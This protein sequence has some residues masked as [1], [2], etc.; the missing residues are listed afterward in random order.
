MS[1]QQPGPP[2]NSSDSASWLAWGITFLLL[3][4]MVVNFV[5]RLVLA[6]V[7]PILRSELHLSNAQYSY[8]VFGFMAGMTL[9]QLPAGMFIDWIGTRIALP[10]LLAGWSSSNMLHALARGVVTFSGLRFV[11]GLFECGN[12]SAGLKVIGRIFPARQRALALGVFDSGSLVGSVIAPPLIVYVVEHFGW[13]AAFW[14][15]SALGLLWIW[16]WFRV[17]R[18][19]NGRDLRGDSV[20]PAITVK[21]LLSW[22]QTWGVILMRA[23]SD[24]VSQFYWY[25]LPLYLVRGRGLSMEAMA[26]LASGAYLLGGAGQITGG[27]LSGFLIAHRFTVDQAR[28][29]AFSAGG[30]LTILAVIVPLIPNVRWACFMIGLAIFGLSFISCN[31]IAIIT[32]VFPES[33]LGRVTG[34]TGIGGGVMNMFLTV[35]TGAA[36]DRFSFAPVFVGAGAMPLLSMAALF[37]LVRRCIKIAEESPQVAVR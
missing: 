5:N 8:I 34:L 3:A 33:T 15:P 24:P 18:N 7:A 19:G 10:T 31:L 11:M 26:A 23:F 36:V 2:R 30:I 22:R 20:G 29:I 37:L 16:P 27:Y 9:G 4:S 35:A 1:D 25:W 17:N 28:K 21:R 13:R 6:T 32:D 12:Y 14:I